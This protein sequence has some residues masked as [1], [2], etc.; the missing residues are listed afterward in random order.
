ML[1]A[2]AVVYLTCAILV[3]QLPVAAVPVRERH[4]GAV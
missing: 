1:A 3:A 2:T 4:L